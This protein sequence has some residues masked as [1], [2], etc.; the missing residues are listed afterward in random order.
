MISSGA[1][2]PIIGYGALN[3]LLFMSYNRS[4]MFLDPSVSDPTNPSSIP[5]Y[6]IWVAGAAGGLASW[7][8]SS[9][10]ELIK[11]RA[12]LKS[13]GVASS[14]VIAKAVLK[15]RGLQGLYYGGTVTSLRD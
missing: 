1:A 8:V 5:S 15:I 14:W 3:A 4:L 9:P 11:C 7:A 10:T 13:N 2:A 6:K 12:Q